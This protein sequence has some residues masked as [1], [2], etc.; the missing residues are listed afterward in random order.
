MTTE[1]LAVATPT[2]D[3]F[4]VEL[5][6]GTRE[7]RWYQ[8][9]AVNQAADALEK[10][11]KRILI[12]IPT[13]GG[14]T[15]TIAASMSNTRV[16]HALGVIG[17]R[18]LR[19][20]FVA[21]NHRL[22]TQG[23]QTFVEDSNVEIILQS[24][25]SDIPQEVLDAGWDICILD[26]A[27]HEACMSFQYHIQNISGK[28]IIGLTATPDRADGCVIKFEVIIEP[29]SREQA[30][31]EGFLAETQLFS[32]VDAPEKDKVEIV[33]DMI[34]KYHTLMGQ[35]MVFLR[36]KKEVVIITNLLKSLGLSA[37]GILNQTA[38]ELD[39]ILNEF[40]EKKYQFLVNCNKINEGVDVK[41]CESVVLG[42]TYGSYPQLNQVIG[43]ASRPDSDCKVWEIINPLS[44]SN[45]DTTVVVGTP[46]EHKLFY[47]EGG[48]WIETKFDYSARHSS[49]MDPAEVAKLRL[50]TATFSHD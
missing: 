28:P 6:Y 17:D 35:T 2:E 1:L 29:I 46:K 47:R 45:L 13:G 22:L 14:K 40:S 25:A 15:L 19:V 50:N 8:I 44:S 9:A 23:E 11:V 42:R 39:R 32:F 3:V 21:H 16:R 5:Y 30:V 31:K 12:V 48:E 27:H 20:L 43:R 41:G 49:I 10:G 37:V 7:L 26:E 24:M 38:K 36:T 33:T 34:T 18:P 4:D